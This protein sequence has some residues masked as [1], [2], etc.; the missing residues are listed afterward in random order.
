MGNSREPNL[1]A[2]L[3]RRA[4]GAARRARDAGRLLS[5]GNVPA[6]RDPELLPA[7]PAPAD[8]VMPPMYFGWTRYSA[9]YPDSKAFV[10]SREVPNPEAYKRQLWAADRMITRSHVFLDL[11]V[12][13]FQRMR[14]RHDYRHVVTHS[15]DMPDPWQSQLHDAADTHDVLILQPVE[16]TKLHNTMKGHLIRTG[17]PSRVVVWFRIDDDD[18]LGLNYLDELSQYANPHDRGRAVSMARGYSALWDE[19]SV[20]HIRTAH[21]RLGSQ[22]QAYV[23]WWDKDR[24]EITF[25][26]AGSHATVDDRMPTILDSRPHVFMQ[27]RHV[28]QDTSTKLAGIEALRSKHTSVAGVQ[29][30]EPVFEQFPTLR[31]VYRPAP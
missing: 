1:T 20:T 4:L 21:R 8:Q 15:S 13:L 17:S 18:L 23:G 22:G 9:F 12:P 31:G 3:R 16:S 5:T 30:L 27:L 14:E 28:G 29:D 26:R 25:P 6:G 7:W 19:G 10:V 2:T 11:S 24:E